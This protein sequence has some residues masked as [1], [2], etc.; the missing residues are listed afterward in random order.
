MKCDLINELELFNTETQRLTVKSFD[1]HFNSGAE[2][3]FSDGVS[4]EN[5]HTFLPEAGELI[6]EMADLCA[7]LLH[8]LNNQV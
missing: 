1:Q 5:T 2:I 7:R 4:P 6:A 8:P 3:G